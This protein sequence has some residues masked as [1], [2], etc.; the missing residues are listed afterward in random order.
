[1]EFEESEGEE[2][3]EEEEEP[4]EIDELLEKEKEEL[5]EEKTSEEGPASSPE[6]SET[7]TQESPAE[8]TEASDEEDEEGEG[9]LEDLFRSSSESEG[10]TSVL[11]VTNWSIIPTFFK[12]RNRKCPSFS[13]LRILIIH[14]HQNFPPE[15]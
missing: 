8:I 9:S 4:Q 11:K 12:S 6:W 13:P 2:E 10:A 7:D 1:M 14:F 3:T 5:E 15:L